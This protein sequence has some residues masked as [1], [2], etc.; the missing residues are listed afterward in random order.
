MKMIST[1]KYIQ[2]HVY[3]PKRYSSLLQLDNVTQI[4]S[5][6]YSETKAKWKWIQSIHNVLS[7]NISARRTCIIIIVVCLNLLIKCNLTELT[8]AIT[9]WG[10]WKNFTTVTKHMICMRLATSLVAEA[11]IPLKA[12]VLH[13]LSVQHSMHSCKRNSSLT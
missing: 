12:C 13:R 2:L 4:Y 8:F 3:I 11:D 7:N 6:I 9:Y 5:Q 10:N 1:I